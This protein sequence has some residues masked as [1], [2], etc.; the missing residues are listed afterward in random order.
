V[1]LRRKHLL[2]DVPT[3]RIR[4]VAM[5]FAELAGRAKVRTPLTA[6]FSGI[7]C[8]FYRFQVEEER[9]SQRG[10]RWTTVEQG[11]TTEPFYLED[12]TGTLMVDPSGAE[13]VLQ[14]SYR[15]FR[16][17]E[18][19][20]ARR[21]RLSEWWIVP[22][23]KLFIAGTVRRLR[24]EALERRAV[25][26][27]RLRELKH[28]QERLKSFDTDQDGQIST[29]EWGNA[30]LAVRN[31]LV[32]EDLKAPPE[33][34]EETIG[35]GKGSDETT[36]VIAERGERPL[37]LRLGLTSGAAI[38]CGSLAVTAFL[39]SLLTRAGVLSGWVFP[40]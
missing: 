13:T 20:F 27:D 36:F 5:G 26:N 19:W 21:K 22:G 16:R 25:L 32:Q 15:T 6:P 40:W 12:E 7:P 9:Q 38:V 24:D 34:P 17:D 37:L 33:P 1:V 11:A 10:R 4:S 31:E 23:Q 3:S 35:V 14:R 30:V 39:V 29:E 28:D 2:E 8:V 18:G